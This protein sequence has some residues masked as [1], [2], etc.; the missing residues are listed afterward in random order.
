MSFETENALTSVE[1]IDPDVVVIELLTTAR[2]RMD[3]YPRYRVLRETAPVHRSSLG[4]WILS[5]YEDCAAVLN[6]SRLTKDYARQNDSRIGPH[7][8]DH[9]SLTDGERSLVNLDGPAHERL[10]RLVGKAFTRRT[11]DALRPG[12]EAAVRKL[13]DPIAETG[14]GNLLEGL[15][16][17]LALGVIG[18]MLGVPSADQAQFPHLVRDILAVFETRPTDSQLAIADRAQLKF[19]EYFKD[20]VTE[21]RR[22]PGQDFLSELISI[23][24][25]GDRLSDEELWALAALLF[26]AGF[27]T[28]S[29]QICNGILAVLT[30]PGEHRKLRANPDLLRALPEEL[31]R[32]DGTAQMTVRVTTA[33]FDVGGVII[34]AD[35][36]ILVLLGAANRDPARYPEPDR[37]NVMRSNIRPLT[38]GGG[39]HVCLGAALAR[40]EVEIVIRMLLER[41]E[42]LALRAKPRFRDR[43]TLRGLEELDV[44]AGPA[45]S[46]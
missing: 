33:Q 23:E 12:I 38:F 13:L 44:T 30:H 3:P 29:H 41:F 14:G 8:R 39:V 36:T 5:R 24:E 20:L 18:D 21:K 31:L 22:T 26:G 19:R 4:M 28:T 37:L 2:G 27:E 32:Y 40:A 6:S 35:A 17:P 11:V 25:N 15:A 43:L 7:W 34:P 1:T 9:V 16:F 42:H 10:R 46:N 45:R